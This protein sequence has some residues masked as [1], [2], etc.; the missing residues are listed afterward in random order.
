[1]LD[2]DQIIIGRA[3]PYDHGGR[4]DLLNQMKSKLAFLSIAALLVVSSAVATIIRIKSGND[5]ISNLQNENSAPLTAGTASAGDGALLEYGYYSLTTNAESFSGIWNTLTGPNSASMISTTIGD[6]SSLGDGIFGLSFDSSS[7]LAGLTS[8]QTPL[9]IRFYNSATPADSTAF[10]AVAVTDGGWNWVVSTS[11]V[12]IN[13]IVDPSLALIWQG[14]P[15]SAQRTTL[16][17]PE[18]SMPLLL[19]GSV[20]VWGLGRRREKRSAYAFHHFS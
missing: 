5:A 2:A 19:V 18:P 1:M 12:L 20:V 10:N 6:G 17:I 9:A 11:F 4:T 14:G 15:S 8:D 13:M 3:S 7:T 16:P